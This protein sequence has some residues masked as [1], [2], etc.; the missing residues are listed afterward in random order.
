[1]K[2]P[3][4]MTYE[5]LEN[6]RDWAEAEYCPN[7]GGRQELPV[8]DNLGTVHLGGNRT[9]PMIVGFVTC[10]RCNGTGRA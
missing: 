7:C 4:E 8:Y 1:M 3:D 9:R 2:R 5:E 6:Y 10:H